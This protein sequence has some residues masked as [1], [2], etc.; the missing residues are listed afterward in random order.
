MMEDFFDTLDN[1]VEYTLLAFSALIALGLAI[2]V[3]GCIVAIILNVGHQN[4]VIGAI[5]F[6][7]TVL[8]AGFLVWGILHKEKTA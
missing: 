4:G 7:M 6:S 2:M 8:Q 5:L 1:F 3:V